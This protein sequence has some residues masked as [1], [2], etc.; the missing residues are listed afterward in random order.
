MGLYPQ[1]PTLVQLLACERTRRRV[2]ECVCVCVCMCG[3][4]KERDTCE[5]LTRRAT[6]CVSLTR[7]PLTQN[8]ALSFPMPVTPVGPH[9]YLNGSMSAIYM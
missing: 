3:A 6:K 7:T 4:L 1:A 2:C 8:G 5:P 9:L